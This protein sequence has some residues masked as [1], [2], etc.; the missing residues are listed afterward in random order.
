MSDS[1]QLNVTFAK[2]ISERL[3][4]GYLAIIW[5]YLALKTAFV[6]FRREYVFSRSCSEP[7]GHSRETFCCPEM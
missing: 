4:W 6:A 1:D 3:F 2:R 5:G 7:R